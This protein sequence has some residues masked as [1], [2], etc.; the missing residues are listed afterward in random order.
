MIQLGI[1]S[2]AYLGGRLIDQGLANSL[3]LATL[4]HG[5]NPFSWISIH[6]LGA[7]PAL[8]GNSIGGDYGNHFD[9]QNRGRVYF[10][11]GMRV[12]EI[13]VFRKRC[14]IR[15]I[16]KGYAARSTWNLLNKLIPMSSKINAYL[17]IPIGVLLPTIKFRFTNLEVK[18]MVQDPTTQLACSTNKWVSPLNIGIIGTVYKS[19]TNH[20]FTLIKEHPWR[21]ITGLAQLA[22]SGAIVY[23]MMTTVP[24]F[25]VANKVTIVAG[26]AL[27]VL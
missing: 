7:I 4:R 8:G 20:T 16:P 15:A 1:F 22:L 3:G 27:G 18:E 12:S 13:S 17:A 14:L 5:T 26:I 24:A 19:V 21:V 10:A 11:A 23:A 2:A 6:L 25:L 9:Y